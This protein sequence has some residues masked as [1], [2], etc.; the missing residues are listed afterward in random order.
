MILSKKIKLKNAK[1]VE[2]T[3]DDGTKQLVGFVQGD[4]FLKTQ[5]PTEPNPR[6]FLGE[7]NSN[8]T[9]MVKTLRTEPHMFARKNSA[10]IT[11]FATAVDSNGDGS[12]TI[13]FGPNDGIANGGHTYNALRV[14]GRS[15]SQVKVTIE[16]GLNRK[17]AVDIAEALNLS[18]RLPVAT[19][20]NKKGHYDWH[21][22]AL[23]DLASE[24]IYHEGDTGIID[25]REEMAFLNLFKPNYR[26]GE[27]D[28]LHNYA[29]SDVSNTVLTKNTLGKHFDKFDYATK[30]IARDAHQITVYAI[31]N[32]DYVTMLK[33]IQNLSKQRWV[34]P[35][36][37]DKKYGLVKGISLLL[38]AGLVSQTVAINHN[39]IAQWRPEYST[40]VMRKR[41]ID[42]LFAK[43]VDIVTV[44]EGAASSITRSPSV[45]EKVMKHAERIAKGIK[46]EIRNET[47][48]RQTEEVQQYIA[49]S[50]K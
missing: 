41:F 5:I 31:M 14:F 36:G 35:R 26:T 39:G 9:A 2:S 46:T 11:M 33:P 23:G 18:R 38:I 30:F 17:D 1:F 40:Y 32:Q 28:I 27:L 3:F 19:L 44:E 29:Q 21:K 20:Q 34:K 4:S 22:E 50:K 15:N 7:I 12:Y 43:T 13:E 8:Y 24:V 47:L 42:D 6:Q 49:D 25:V 45:R 10:G 48:L 37:T 16:I